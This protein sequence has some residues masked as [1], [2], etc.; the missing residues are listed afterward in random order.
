MQLYPAMTMVPTEH[1]IT[2]DFIAFILF[3]ILNLFPFFLGII[4]TIIINPVTT[5]VKVHI[6]VNGENN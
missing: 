1:I 2:V 3:S 5:G 4:I 6:K